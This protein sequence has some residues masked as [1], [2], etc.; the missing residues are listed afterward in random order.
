MLL[1]DWGFFVKPGRRDEFVAWLEDNEARLL[2]LAPKK[3]EY[4]GTYR[5]LSPEPQDFHQIWRYRSESRPDMR[6]AAADDSGRFT[7]IAREYLSFVDSERESEEVFRLYR[8]VAG[9]RDEQAPNQ[10]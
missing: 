5:A 10:A 8:E 1:Y 9:S 4:L 2:E 3:Y 7:E 6:R